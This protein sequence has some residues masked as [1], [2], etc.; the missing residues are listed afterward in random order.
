MNFFK[1][2]FHPGNPASSDNVCLRHRQSVL[3]FVRDAGSST[4]HIGYPLVCELHWV[5]PHSRLHVRSQFELYRDPA[6]TTNQL[7]FAMLW[8]GNTLYTVHDFCI[9]G[10]V[11]LYFLFH[12]W[13]CFFFYR[14]ITC[15]WLWTKAPFKGSKTTQSLNTRKYFRSGWA[16]ASCRTLTRRATV[17]HPGDA[18]P[19][20]LLDSTLSGKQDTCGCSNTGLCIGISPPD[21]ISACR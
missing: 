8:W 9:Y 18:T 7:Q 1:L 12:Y 5:T 19:Q 14:T 4:V 13:L 15:T 6:H 10:G 16:V 21:D 17:E 3:P 11:Y 20:L 2:Y